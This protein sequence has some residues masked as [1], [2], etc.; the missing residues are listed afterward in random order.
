MGR[1]AAARPAAIATV[2]ATQTI[3]VHH[4]SP[5]G[6]TSVKEKIPART[7][8]TARI[9]TSAAMSAVTQG[10]SVGAERRTMAMRAAVPA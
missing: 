7:P 9:G 10:A 8:S 2:T 4:G 5:S 1:P 6:P 3:G